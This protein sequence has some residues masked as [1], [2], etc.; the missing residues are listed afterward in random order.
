MS[1]FRYEAGG[2][3]CVGSVRKSLL[4]LKYLEMTVIDHNDEIKGILHLG[5]TC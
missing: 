1:I 3:Y 2:K 4:E 5:S